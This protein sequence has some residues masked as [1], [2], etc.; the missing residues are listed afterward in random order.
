[1]IKVD[2]DYREDEIMGDEFWF[3][4]NKITI[5]DNS[6]INNRRN[7]EFVNCAG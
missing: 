4:V 6:F 7:G 5:D 3:S 2:P 1:M